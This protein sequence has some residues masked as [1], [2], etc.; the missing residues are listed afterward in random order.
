M[1]CTSLT[2]TAASVTNLIGGL[3]L[4]KVGGDITI[5][6]AQVMLG[7]AVGT[8]KAGGSSIKLAGGPITI[9]ASSFKFSGAT[10]IKMGSTLKEG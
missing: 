10:I 9:K 6:A 1:V 7:G 4:R 3:H 5:K 2:Q 8:F